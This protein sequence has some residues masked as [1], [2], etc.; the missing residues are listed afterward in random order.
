M[1]LL[2]TLA[3]FLVATTSSAQLTWQPLGPFGGNVTRI[4]AD[5]NAALFAMAD[6]GIYRSTDN[7]L[8]W[9]RNEDVPVGVTFVSFAIA[10]NGAYFASTANG[11]VFRSTNQ[12]LDW[13]AA[14]E[15]LPQSFAWSIAANPVADEVLVAT[16]P[17]VYRTTDN[18]ATWSLTGNTRIAKPVL[19]A[20]DGAAYVAVDSGVMRSS[21]PER[22][23]WSWT[24]SAAAPSL[25]T[26]MV[27]A[28]ADTLW[29]GTDSNGVWR[30]VDGGITWASRSTGLTSMSVEAID[31]GY[32][33]ELYVSTRDGG[34]HRSTD[35]GELWVRINPTL[36]QFVASSILRAPS[37][38]L[39]ATSPKGIFY[40]DAHAIGEE[41]N[42]SR[43]GFTNSVIRTV[44]A[45]PGDQLYAMQFTGIFHRL[46]SSDAS[47]TL[48]DLNIPPGSD[49]TGLALDSSGSLIVA[50]KGV[51]LYRS[52][53]AGA[54][55]TRFSE[56]IPTT[57]P[58]LLPTAIA[59]GP[60]G[61]IYVGSF[62][63]RVFRSTDNGVTWSDDTLS[64]NRGN[65]VN[66]IAVRDETVFVGMED[67]LF[68]S[69][70]GGRAYEA[71]PMSIRTYSLA[72]APGGRVYVGSFQGRVY[73]SNDDGMTWTYGTTTPM[74]PL[75]A[76][77]AVNANGDVL[78]GV[79]PGGMY[80]SRDSGATFTRRNDGL[81]NPAMTSISIDADG[82]AYVGTYGGGVHASIEST[83]G[84]EHSVRAEGII[85]SIA[86]TPA[87][88]QTSVMIMLR[89]SGSVA[90]DLFDAAGAHVAALHDGILQA[91]A[92][93]F[94]IEAATIAAGVYRVR[95][96][97][98]GVAV[99]APFVVVH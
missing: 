50:V 31:N 18:G 56:T 97:V 34:L 88:G 53:D 79:Q 46:S 42:P 86:P 20:P 51:G 60:M 5:S 23:T 58:T 41:W 85:L 57:D 38:R 71:A 78:A 91:G 64:T 68:I 59:I 10:R 49:A 52:V 39:F 36:V 74:A 80:L 77:V 54:T 75:V 83:L 73:R 9:S 32:A 61:R 19:F 93:H 6:N 67:G 16:G 99:Q 55:W 40:N 94:A 30:S 17:G 76:A 22:E 24:D 12:G 29:I 87:R 28:G 98:D 65:R 8:S 81:V 89:R 66:A 84:V 69:R 1:K 95:A 11:G 96:L 48:V 7:G 4:A 47:W 62:D 92:H 25:I 21:D 3:L 82:R 35:D 44:I 14:S 15:G 27:R 37:D 90:L 63:G 13:S 33:G 72:V 45:A 43:T 70:D 26:G 2:H